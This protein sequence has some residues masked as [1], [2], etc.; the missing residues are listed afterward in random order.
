SSEAE[1]ETIR[2]TL[3]EA[4]PAFPAWA[5]DTIDIVEQLKY[6][7]RSLGLAAGPLLDA[8]LAPGWCGIDWRPAIGCELLRHRQMA[9]ATEPHRL[10]HAESPRRRDTAYPARFAG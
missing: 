10:P 5:R 8:S 6:R 7:I 9:R 2:R 1:C 3:Q 4:R